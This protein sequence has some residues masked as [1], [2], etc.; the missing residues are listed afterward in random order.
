MEENEDK[1]INPNAG[2]EA[3]NSKENDGGET[4]ADVSEPR[5]PS[6]THVAIGR[7][8]FIIDRWYKLTIK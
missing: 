6:P 7:S 4:T 1:N 3:E 2:E 8:N 5:C